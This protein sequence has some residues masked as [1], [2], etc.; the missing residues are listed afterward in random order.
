MKKMHFNRVIICLAFFVFS[1]GYGCGVKPQIEIISPE[2][3]AVIT[4]DGF[5]Y[6]LDVEVNVPVPALGPK[7][8]FPVDPDT[9]TAT[10]NHLLD[11][12]VMDTDNV[13]S[14]L[15]QGVV[16][17][18]T[19]AYSWTG[20]VALNDF[21]EYELVFTIENEKGVGSHSVLFKLE[22]EVSAFQGG[23]FRVTVAGLAQ[24][25]RNCL[26]P[27]FLLTI[28]VGMVRNL[29]FDLLLPPGAEI[30]AGGN[31]YPATLFLPFPL[32]MVDVLLRLDELNNDIVIDGP[33]DYTIDL[34]G[35]LPGFDCIITAMADGVFN[36]IDINDLDGYLN[37]NIT[38]VEAS[39][40]GTCNI[41]P[42]DG[43]CAL[44]VLMDS[45]LL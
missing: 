34:S 29:Y 27:D 10:L 28:I 3:N 41:N 26:L 9:F 21:G 36:D 18:D 13:T 15:G 32:T 12:E 25:P 30:L 38:D 40:N 7:T 31:A 35:L 16:N 45:D 33:D 20:T 42:P 24:E 1:M 4:V 5:P 22:Q 11:G 43:D 17:P 44:T 8:Q 37:I 23:L 2:S 6:S 39:I 14:N 19:G